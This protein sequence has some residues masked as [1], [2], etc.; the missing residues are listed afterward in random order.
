MIR[1]LHLCVWLFLVAVA[2]GEDA[3]VPGSEGSV[4]EVFGLK[5]LSPAQ[6]KELIGTQIDYVES[7]GVSMARADDAAY[8]LENALRERGYKSAT[9]D[10]KLKSNNQG[11]LQIHLTVDEG[12]SVALGKIEVSGNEAIEDDAVIELITSQTRKRVGSEPGVALPFVADDIRKGVARV[13]EFYQLLGF[14]DVE[15]TSTTF[16]SETHLSNIGVNIEEGVQYRV[17]TITFPDAAPTKVAESYT[18]LKSI[19]ESKSY[20][21]AIPANLSSRLTSLARDA[22]YYDAV[23]SVDSQN[24]ESDL[25]GIVPVELTVTADWGPSVPVSGIR[26]TGNEKV[27]DRF[28]ERHFEEI[29]GQPYSPNATNRQVEELLRT[30]A[31][32]SVRTN[33][34][35]EEDGSI[36]LQVEVEEAPSRQL[37]VYGGFATYEGPI[38]GFEFRNLNLLGSVRKIDAE[39]EV[40]RRGL[41]GEIEYD[42]PWFAWSEYRLRASL[43]AMNRLNE[44]YSKFETG[45]RYDFSRKL[46]KKKKDSFSVFG[47]ASYTDIY[48]A[49]IDDAELGDK[50]YF[51]HS[52]GVAYSHDRRDNPRM[53]RSGYIAQ[54]SVSMASSA[55]ASEVEFLRATGKLGF[56]LPLG[57]T[58]IRLSARAGVI[59]PSGDTDSLPIDLRFYNG[60]A[61][62]VRSFQER[63]LGPSSNGHPVGGQFYSIFNFEYD[64]PFPWVNGLS[65][66]PFADAGNLLTDADDIGLYD[67]RYAVGLGLRYDTPIGPLR[68]E[69]GYNPDRRIDEAQGA[70]HV[71]MGVA[72]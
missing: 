32:E 70:V 47:Q 36:S 11:K 51:A 63:E 3:V 37:G 41:R 49:E 64:I 10:W 26:V 1:F 14:L 35:R 67:M 60:G 16:P 68:V 19:F 22:G 24:L 59:S 25:E 71:G 39:V 46:G 15:V 30:Q 65:I 21:E 53:P 62:S 66:V 31:F 33:T 27:T 56:Y 8:F 42:D 6:V 69:Y 9:V 55:I 58:T 54:T 18:E 5:T 28:F 50:S 43:F 44:G 40:S 20:S 12:K 4:I 34:V 45:G 52:V 48:E 57:D 2:T 13:K 29:Q 7:S 61:Q 17:G 23:V 38:G 72:Y